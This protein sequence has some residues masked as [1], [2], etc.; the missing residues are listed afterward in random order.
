M[1]RD[2]RVALSIVA[3][4]DPYEQVLIRG[5]VIEIRPDRELAG[6]DALAQKYLGRPFPRRDW[7]SRALYAIEADLA[8]YYKSPLSERRGA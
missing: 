3:P 7:P 2:P 8:R 6:L 1:R 5:R 4:D